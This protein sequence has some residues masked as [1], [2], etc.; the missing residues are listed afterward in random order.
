M[1]TID[2]IVVTGWVGE[3]VGGLVVVDEV[4]GSAEVV[5]V[6]EVVFGVAVLISAVV[7]GAVVLSS[8][9]H[10]AMENKLIIK[11]VVKI[12]GKHFLVTI[13]IFLFC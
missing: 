2:G 13:L 6:I 3:V 11:I 10:P 7:V 9:L 4:V 1:G 12:N 5:W 8:L